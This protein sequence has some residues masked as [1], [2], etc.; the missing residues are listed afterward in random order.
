[1]KSLHTRTASAPLHQAAADCTSPPA[2]QTAQLLA[3]S[4]RQQQQGQ[5]LAQLKAAA[6]PTL[7]LSGRGGKGG[8][9][10]GKGG[11]GGAKGGGKGG[12]KKGGGKPTVSAAEQRARRAQSKADRQ[13]NNAAKYSP[14]FVKGQ[15]KAI[16]SKATREI[17]KRVKGH[18]SQNNTK[19][20]N[21][22][23]QQSLN[24]AKEA[25]KKAK[26]EARAEKARKEK[27]VDD[28]KKDF[29]HDRR[30][31]GGASGASAILVV[32]VH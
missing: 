20:Q 27:D 17:N 9:K 2:R 10:G 19:G 14:D 21:A 11:K 29:H 23:T 7:Q 31:G 15:E 1:M 24:E 25:T 22:A 32:G 26:E 4:P 5:R 12:G 18:A 30:D 28:W 6:E 13:A 3:D 8:G 16:G